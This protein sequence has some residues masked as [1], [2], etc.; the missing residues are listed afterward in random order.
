MR[1]LVYRLAFREQQHADIQLSALGMNVLF[2]QCLRKVHNE[3]Q[4]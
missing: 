2:R 4:L 3:Q 1:K